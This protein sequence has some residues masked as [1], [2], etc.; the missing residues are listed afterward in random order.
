LRFLVDNALSPSVALGLRGVGH[1]AVHVRDYAMQAAADLEI[2]LLAALEDRIAIS[3]DTGFGT[4]LATRED[5]KPSIILF[6][7]GTERRPERQL[8]LLLSNLPVE[9]DLVAGAIVVFE[10]ARLRIRRLP[11]GSGRET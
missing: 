6:R 11:I 10:Q 9:A 2:L 8:L 4:L 3:A 1:D 7:H 5:E